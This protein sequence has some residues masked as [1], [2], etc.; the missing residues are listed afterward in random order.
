[1]DADESKSKLNSKST[2][3]IN[4]NEIAF[5]GGSKKSEDRKEEDEAPN[6]DEDLDFLAGKLADDAFTHLEFS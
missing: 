2:T 3:S 5:L 4:Q 1:M 6:E